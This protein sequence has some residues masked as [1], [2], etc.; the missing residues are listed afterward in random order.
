MD[1]KGLKS[2][3][4]IVEDDQSIADGIV[5]ALSSE[6]FSAVHVCSGIEALAR[7]REEDFNLVILDVGLPDMSGF[8]LCRQLKLVLKAIPIIFLTARSSEID[9]IVGLEIGANDY[10]TKP[11]SPRELT[12]RVRSLL[13]FTDE[14]RDIA[15]AQQ[16]IAEEQL[17]VHKKFPFHLDADRCVI[18]YFNCPLNLSR[19][20]F[21][22]L[23]VLIKRP[24]WVYSREK[25][26]EMAWEQPEASMDRTVD[27]HIK[28]LRV[29]LKDIRPDIE[30]V[31][32]HRGLGYSI[33]ESW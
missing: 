24:G 20:E 10:L 4:L 5:Y 12:A 3:L 28:T 31:V 11:F 18:L 33:K 23:C 15:R 17:V 22:I 1:A 30:A 9:R 7:I 14:L 25:L 26:M 27:T 16:G 32:T 13:R 2:H 8:D 19:Q 6:G 29:K 21:R